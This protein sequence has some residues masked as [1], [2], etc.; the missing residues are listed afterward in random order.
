[1][2]TNSK[3]KI[4]LATA[5]LAPLAKTG[6]LA[7]VS[8][9]LSAYL[10][11]A[12]HDVRVLM[13]FYSRIDRTGLRIEPVPR[14]QNLY[15]TVGP[16]D[17][18]YSID[19]VVLP[20]NGLPVYLLRCPALYD[21]PEIYGSGTDEHLRFIFLSRVAIEMC[22]HMQFAPD[23]FHCNDWHTALIP[24]YLRTVYSW[25]RLFARTRSI[26]TIHNIGYQGVFSADI[27]SDLNLG[28]S[29]DR[30]HQDD[31]SQGRINFLKTGVLYA[32]LLT[33]VSPTYAREIQGTE[34]GI[35]LDGYLRQRSD[36]LIGILN[37]VDYA[38]W[39][40]ATDKLIPHRYSPDDMSGKRVCKLGLMREMG[41]AGT[42][43][44][45]VIGIVTRLVSQKG[46]DLM[47]KVLPDLLAKRNFSLAVLGSGEPHYE[48]F[49]ESLQRAARGRVSYYRGYN[50]RLAHWIEAGSDMFLMPSLYEPCGL[51]Q[52]YSLKYGTIPVVRATGGLADSVAQ[53][54]PA[55]GTG[56]GVLFS[57]Y[58]E[59]GLYW[60]IS[61]ALTLQA[62]QPLW[63]K[64]ISNGMAMDFSWEKQG[65]QYVKLYRW[66]AGQ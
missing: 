64:I 33:T 41:L 38:E 43:R 18:E 13:P 35:G 52:L 51:N 23:I 60:A 20:T 9:A 21:R 32:D 63:Q 58:D 5:E 42:S 22:Q 37:G 47:V 50:N 31:L 19:R 61:T 56:T 36:R 54:N 49:F 28:Y 1:M 4:C 29:T 7:D 8:A 39:N 10:H 14:L 26:L 24:L 48:L 2:A 62:N 45:P 3:L 12:G 57:D 17:I 40:P 25:D 59:A 44:Q 66:L 11:H 15:I 55:R 46:I 65:Q 27:L 6:G 30:L 16:W 34:Y 53:I